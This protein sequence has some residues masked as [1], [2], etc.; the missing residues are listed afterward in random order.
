VARTRK[1]AASSCFEFWHDDSIVRG[2]EITLRGGLVARAWGV[3]VFGDRAWG[4]ELYPTTAGWPCNTLD[5]S[6]HS[7]VII[8]SHCATCLIQLVVAAR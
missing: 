5:G 7:R 4:K 3:N 8:L 6:G 2:I 1:H